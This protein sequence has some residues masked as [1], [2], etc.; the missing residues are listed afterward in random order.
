MFRVSLLLQRL[1]L[2]FVQVT[3]PYG[4]QITNAMQLILDG[5]T[6]D[7]MRPAHDLTPHSSTPSLTHSLTDSLT[8]S[9]TD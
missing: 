5:L 3:T 4:I 2:I 6:S 7:G 1:Y 9:L 8:H